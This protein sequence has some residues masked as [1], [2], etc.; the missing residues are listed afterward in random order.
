MRSAHHKTTANALKYKRDAEG[1]L[2]IQNL[3]NDSVA[4]MLNILSS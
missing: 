4:S 1:L 3:K 2:T